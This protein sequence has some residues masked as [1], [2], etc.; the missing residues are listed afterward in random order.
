MM[1][2]ES[3]AATRELTAEHGV[4]CSRP[5]ER[6]SYF[7]WPSVARLG[8]GTL[9]AASSGLRAEHIRMV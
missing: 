1:A 8:D 3:P 2:D 5:G 4:V 9:M 7:G 6:F